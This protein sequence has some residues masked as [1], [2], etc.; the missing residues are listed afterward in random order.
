M[1]C[2]AFMLTLFRR[3]DGSHMYAKPLPYWQEKKLFRITDSW[4]Q[5]TKKDPE[6]LTKIVNIELCSSK[7]GSKL[8]G[9]DY[10]P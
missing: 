9:F 6:K 2:P 1:D 5:R 4:H 3:P 10:T 7:L 8:S